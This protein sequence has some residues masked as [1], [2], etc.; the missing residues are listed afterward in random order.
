LNDGLWKREIDKHLIKPPPTKGPVPDPYLPSTL[1]DWQ[2]GDEMVDIDWRASV[3]H[4]GPMAGA[5]PLRRQKLT[6][7]PVEIAKQIP[8]C[9]I[10][11][12]TSG[13]MTPPSQGINPMTLAAQ[14]LAASCI[15]H[16]GRVRG[17]V[18]S[19]GD[20]G[21]IVQK[22]WLTSETVAREFFMNFIGQGTELPLKTMEKM[23]RDGGPARGAI[24]VIVSDKDLNPTVPRN[25]NAIRILKD[26]A[27]R[28]ERIVFVLDGDGVP[29]DVQKAY[30]AI[31]PKIEVAVADRG[32]SLASVMR[33]VADA[34]FGK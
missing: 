4:R 22:E 16:N 21:I 33:G 28:S 9:E 18:W 19:N 27:T 10:Y 1:V 8:S 15:R 26:I 30:R 7:E 29:S 12:D 24:R 2:M 13:S 32:S 3:I 17:A 6:D 11:L 20:D 5:I 23:S 25:P 31:D 34:L 14:V